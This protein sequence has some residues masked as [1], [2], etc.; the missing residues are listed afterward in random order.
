VV[1][2]QFTVDFNGKCRLELCHLNPWNHVRRLDFG[3]TDCALRW[4]AGSRACSYDKPEAVDFQFIKRRALSRL[5]HI[6]SVNSDAFAR[7]KKGESFD[8]TGR[9]RNSTIQGTS[10][11]SDI[12]PRTKVLLSTGMTHSEDVGRS[13]GHVMPRE[14]EGAPATFTCRS[15]VCFRRTTVCKVANSTIS[16][17]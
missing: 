13:N 2:K 3:S 12:A 5:S 7:V 11:F 10:L 4:A 17:R 1:L 14:T 15:I 16:R 9:S 6:P 8:V